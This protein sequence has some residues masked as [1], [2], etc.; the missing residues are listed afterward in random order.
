MQFNYIWQDVR[1]PL[2]SVQCDCACAY[3][4]VLKMAEKW[5]YNIKGGYILHQKREKIQKDMVARKL[6]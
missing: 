4:H 1:Q 3:V 5:N 2:N 6:E